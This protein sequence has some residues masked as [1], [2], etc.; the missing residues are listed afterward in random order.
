MKENNFYSSKY[1]S[2]FGLGFGFLTLTA[3]VEPIST[4]VFL[5]KDKVLMNMEQYQS[6]K[7]YNSLSVSELFDKNIPIS[8]IEEDNDTLV[9]LPFVPSSKK[10]T[11]N[12]HFSGIKKYETVFNPK[13]FA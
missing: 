3:S 8:G 1:A 7:S 11:K 12:F 10:K 2:F 5:E 13:F 4:P 9:Y 6:Q